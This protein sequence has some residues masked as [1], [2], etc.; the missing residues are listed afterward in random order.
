MAFVADIML[1][2]VARWLRILGAEAIYPS[3]TDDDAL[4]TLAQKEGAVLLTRDVELARR[5]GKKGI[6]C[7][8][9]PKGLS[10]EEALALLVREFNLKLDDFP[11]R[12]L[13][14][15]CNGRLRTVGREEVKGKVHADLL[16]RHEKF[17]LC[18]SCGQAY[19]EGSH[20]RK[21]V[22]GVERIRKLMEK[23]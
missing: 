7:F 22:N 18:S 3:D 12:T 8:L 2:K 23:G 16:A 17:W 13:C 10:N 9:L 11:S 5:A 14:P 19:W 20:W 4:L 15:K 1:K 21:I 6:R